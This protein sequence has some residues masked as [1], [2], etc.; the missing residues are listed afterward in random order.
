MIMLDEG[1]FQHV[2]QSVL[3]AGVVITPWSRSGV[4]TDSLQLWW[5]DDESGPHFSLTT[6]S[7]T[8]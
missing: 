7:D 8:S 3:R 6:L 4:G 5:S 1:D 2:F